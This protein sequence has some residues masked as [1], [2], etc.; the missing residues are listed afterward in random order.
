MTAVL[1]PP[2]RTRNRR[3]LGPWALAAAVLAGQ[4]MAS[5]D[6]AIVNVGGPSIQHDLHL[7]GPALQ[8]AVYAYVLVYAIALILGARLGGRYGFGRSFAWGT[9]LFTV[10]S[11]ACGLAVTPVM[12][13]AARA[14]QGLGA[15]LLVPQVLSLLQT[16]FQGQQR[17]R[18]LSLY[19]MVLAVGVAAGQVLGGILVSADLL[20]TGW[21]PIFLV[22]VPVGLIVLAC[23]AGRLPAGPTTGSKR[24]DLA[25]AALLATAILAMILPVTFG[26]D[27]GWPR[28]C[29]PALAAGGLS[30]MAFA[31]HEARL[32]REGRGPLVDP[33]LLAQRDVRTGLAGI[34]ILMGCYGGLLFTT[35]LY[36]QHTLHDS[37][38]RSGL[39]FAGYAAGF[40]AA[41]LTWPRLPATWHRRVPGT[42]FAVIATATAALTWATSSGGWPWQATGLLAVAGAG[43]GVGFG[44]L[45]QRTASTVPAEHA[46]SISGVLSTINQLAIVI[47]IAAAGTLYLSV[48]P[49]APLPAMSWVLLAI[50]G[51]HAL[52]GAAVSIALARRPAAT[53][54]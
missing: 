17:R 43:H 27:A 25:G 21:R 3:R 54:A 49:A 24:L 52:A 28:W 15:A 1:S 39:T 44:A 50:A 22:N 13:V 35:A 14:A 10:S 6:T 11:L 7:S 8:L 30:L 19:G 40:A 34:F 37:A 48:S 32:A 9:A 23:S 2:P 36:L 41:S 29:W 16:T 5:L 45:V 20:G 53:S 4:A 18:A 38:L 46:A 12:L 33:A 42:G 47:G 26:A 31:V 51:S